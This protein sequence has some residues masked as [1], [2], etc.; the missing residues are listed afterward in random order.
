MTT[1][2]DFT[3]DEWTRIVRAPFVAGMAISL[4]D[5]GGPIEAT[6]ETMATLKCATNPP[7]REQLLAEVALEIQSMTQEHHNPLK[8]YKPSKEGPPPGQQIVDELR[9][10][11]GAGRRQGHSEETEAF[12][13]WM[14]TS[15]QAAADAAKEGG[16]MGFDAQRVSEREQSDAGAGP[17]RCRWLIRERER[18][19]KDARHADPGD[20][21]GPVRQVAGTRSRCS[22]AGPAVRT[23]RRG[24]G[25]TDPDWAARI[26]AHRARRPATGRRSRPVTWPRRWRPTEAVLV[27]CLGTWLTA[28]GR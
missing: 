18:L 1:K 27:D 17:R 14:V 21:W 13:R 19:C 28:R 26:A 5:P 25:A 4:A 6:K 24:R 23:S 10:V 8:G 11:H 9:A 7:S 12:G 2:G 3:E 22:A 20:R 16:F 15:A